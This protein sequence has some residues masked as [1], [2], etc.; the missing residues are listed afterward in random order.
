MTMSYFLVVFHHAAGGTE[1]KYK[2]LC[3]LQL[4]SVLLLK[5]M[6]FNSGAKGLMPACNEQTHGN[7]IKTQ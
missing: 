4:N 1:L 5:T 3:S 7:G 6:V 2:I